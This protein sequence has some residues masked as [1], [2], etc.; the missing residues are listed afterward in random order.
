MNK[1]IRK[2]TRASTSTV[3]EKYLLNIVYENLNQKNLSQS[4]ALKPMA[5][6]SQEL[7]SEE[8]IKSDS[9]HCHN[10]ENLW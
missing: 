7:T 1:I 9:S 5:I 2:A 3:E 4:E 6:H 8:Q 10:G